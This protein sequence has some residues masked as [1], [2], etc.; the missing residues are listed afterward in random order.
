MCRNLWNTGIVSAEN[1]PKREVRT[2]PNEN[3]ESGQRHQYITFPF[4]EFKCLL[5]VHFAHL[6]IFSWCILI[7]KLAWC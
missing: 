3:T 7:E 5:F 2:N 6:P 1:L 4:D